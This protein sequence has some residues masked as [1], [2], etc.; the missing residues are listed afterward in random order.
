MVRSFV[1]KIFFKVLYFST[2]MNI[3]VI[4]RNISISNISFWL[5]T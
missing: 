5:L 2:V 4:S 1:D 3:H